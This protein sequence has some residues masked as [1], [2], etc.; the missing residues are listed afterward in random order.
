VSRFDLATGEREIF[1]TGIP[2]PSGLAEGAGAVWISSETDNQIGQVETGELDPDA[3]GDVTVH[4]I[5]APGFDI[6]V[7]GL[8]IYAP[9]VEDGGE[10]E[11]IDY[12]VR[13]IER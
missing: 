6:A 7:N 2:A 5:G 11:V 10:V 3:R 9:N 1:D 4:N 12:D 8:T 13:E